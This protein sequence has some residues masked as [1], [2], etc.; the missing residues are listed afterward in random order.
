MYLFYHELQIC[1][2]TADASYTREIGLHSTTSFTTLEDGV[3]IRMQDSVL[4]V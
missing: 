1:E 2:V 4:Y 3:I